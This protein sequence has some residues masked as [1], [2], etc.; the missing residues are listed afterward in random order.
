MESVALDLLVDDLVTRVASLGGDSNDSGN[1]SGD[2]TMTENASGSSMTRGNSSGSNMTTG[3]SMDTSSNNNSQ[4]ENTNN[5]SSNE[6]LTA[7]TTRKRKYSYDKEWDLEK[8]LTGSVDGRAVLAYYK[9]T[10]D[11]N[12][13]MRSLLGDCIMNEHLREDY[14]KKFSYEMEVCLAEKVVE[15]FPTEEKSVW[16]SPNPGGRES[17]EGRRKLVQRYYSKR[18]FLR[19]GRLLKKTQKSKETPNVSSDE[20]DEDDPSNDDILWLKNNK[21]PW[22]RVEELWKATSAY[23]LR[24]LRAGTSS[25]DSYMS[26][27]PA[28]RDPIGYLLLEMDF[29]LEF[30]NSRVNLFGE[31]PNLSAFIE[32]KLP[33]AELSKIENCLTPEGKRIKTICALPYLFQVSTCAKKGKNKQW[34]P[35]RYE[36]GEALLLHVKTIGDIE[37]T[38]LNR[39]KEKYEPYNLTLGPQAI[40]VGPDVD[41]IEQSYIRINNILYKVDNARKAIDITFKIFHSLDGKYHTEAEREWLFLERAV[42]GINEGKGGDGRIKS[43]CAEYLKFKSSN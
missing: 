19:R 1:A 2:N 27:Y 5:G 29:D 31:W 7:E 38:L 36:V 42:Y 21:Q 41:S 24:K 26:A 14:D 30:P 17:A 9:D 20:E 13:D 15:L 37:P 4:R 28:L 34:R 10:N 32:S 43:V 40:V 23:R 6:V 39:L 22:S 18:R 12:D 8:V 16:A 11:F 35:S 25:T 3:E 33:K